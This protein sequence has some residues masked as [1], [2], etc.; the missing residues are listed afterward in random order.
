MTADKRC[1]KVGKEETGWMKDT[2][3]STGARDFERKQ[4]GE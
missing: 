3:D 4:K 2:W 1:Q